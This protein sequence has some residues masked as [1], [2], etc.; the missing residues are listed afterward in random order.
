[1]EARREQNTTAA[2][3][4][5][6][7]TSTEASTK[8]TDRRERNGKERRT[9]PGTGRETETDMGHNGLS[10]HGFGTECCLPEAGVEEDSHGLTRAEE[11]GS[12]RELGRGRGG[13]TAVRTSSTA[14]RA[15]D[16]G[17]QRERKR[18]RA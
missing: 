10:E 12:G 13:T 6:M 15:R 3:G 1:M 4:T 18:A 2:T 9:G 5:N 17:R 8:E 16:D 11:V 7:D 14:A